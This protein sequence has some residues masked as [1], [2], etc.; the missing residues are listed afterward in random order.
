MASNGEQWGVGKRET[1]TTCHNK[2]NIKCERLRIGN[3]IFAVVFLFG[4][5]WSMTFDK[6]GHNWNIISYW[7]LLFCLNFLPFPL[8]CVRFCFVCLFSFC[9]LHTLN[10]IYSWAVLLLKAAFITSRIWS[11]ESKNKHRWYISLT[12]FTISIFVWCSQF[13]LLWYR[14]I[15]FWSLKSLQIFN[16]SVRWS[17]DS[18]CRSKDSSQL[19]WNE[20]GNVWQSK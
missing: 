11:I 15:H 14:Q 13:Y 3:G 4:L 16:L 19:W 20:Y 12:L 7:L 1:E 10:G 18:Y 9:V 6:I 5:I 8:C 17:A 2:H